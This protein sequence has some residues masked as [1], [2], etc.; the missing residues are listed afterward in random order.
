[1]PSCCSFYIII[2]CLVFLVLF[3]ESSN[4]SELSIW[5]SDEES[6]GIVPVCQFGTYTIFRLGFA[7]VSLR[8]RR[9]PASKLDSFLHWHVCLEF[10]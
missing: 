10:G 8:S 9:L 5:Q 4:F 2:F 6:D 7:S 3:V 1:M